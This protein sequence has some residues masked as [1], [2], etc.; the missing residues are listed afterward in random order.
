MKDKN[1]RKPPRQSW[2]TLSCGRYVRKNSVETVFST[3]DMLFNDTMEYL[4]FWLTVSV[5][6]IKIPN[7]L[8]EE[9]ELEKTASTELGDT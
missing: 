4:Q 2:K 9:G 3:H 1:F 5:C 8:D 7:S 6:E